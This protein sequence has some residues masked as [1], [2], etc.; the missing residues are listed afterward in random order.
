MLMMDALSAS[1]VRLPD[2]MVNVSVYMPFSAAAA[3]EADVVKI[4]PC[5]EDESSGSVL[6]SCIVAVGGGG[7]GSV[8]IDVEKIS[9]ARLAGHVVCCC[10]G[11]EEKKQVRQSGAGIHEKT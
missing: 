1:C 2:G 8:F 7:V 5:A 10:C 3:A 6:I 9:P 11:V 4:S